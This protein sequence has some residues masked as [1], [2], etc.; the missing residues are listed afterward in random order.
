[1][2][3]NE[4]V[5]LDI[6]STTRTLGHLASIRFSI[7]IYVGLNAGKTKYVTA[8]GRRGLVQTVQTQ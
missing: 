1:M 7:T 6:R 5:L 3:I 4:F 2:Q 8:H